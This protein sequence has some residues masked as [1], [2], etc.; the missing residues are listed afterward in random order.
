MQWR[1]DLLE[2][3]WQIVNTSENKTEPGSVVVRK[4]GWPTVSW[5]PIVRSSIFSGVC[6]CECALRINYFVD[7]CPVR[8]DATEVTRFFDEMPWNH[9][10]DYSIWEFGVINERCRTREMRFSSK[11]LCD[12]HTIR[13]ITRPRV[14]INF[15]IESALQDPDCMIIEK[16]VRPPSTYGSVFSSRV[17]RSCIDFSSNVAERR[18]YRGR[19]MTAS[20]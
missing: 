8:R 5:L 1:H 7:S 15:R 18:S 20:I 16:V 6:M 17:D 10:V 12:V 3:L 4:R 14:S 2:V 9:R 11:T 19:I 13:V